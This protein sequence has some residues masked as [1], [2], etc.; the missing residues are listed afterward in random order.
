MFKRK[1]SKSE[2]VHAGS[3]NKR[4][5]AIGD[6]HGCYAEMQSLLDMIKADHTALPEKECIIVF[7]GD[8]IDRGPESQKVLESLISSPPDFAKTYALIGNH[9]EMFLRALKDDPILIP[10]WLTY[11]GDTCVQSYGLDPEKLRGLD[12]ADMQVVLKKYI[13]QS[14]IDYIETLYDSINFGDYLLVHAGIDPALDR[15]AQDPRK[16]RWI[17]EP[18]LSY[19]KPLG[20]RVVHGH[21]ITE[22]FEPVITHNR[23]GLDTG[24]Y[25]TGILSAAVIEGETLRI[26]STP[27]TAFPT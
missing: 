26:L 23:V 14:H 20:Y 25:D 21:T 22:T 10:D 19:T 12:P 8:L 2:K 18:F 27:Q 5:Y 4:L 24:C 1:A 6:V 9:E 17:R 11:G 7:L 3:D 15:D 16:V 13:P